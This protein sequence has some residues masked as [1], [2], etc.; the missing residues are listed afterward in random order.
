[1]G[2]KKKLKKAIMHIKNLHTCILKAVEIG[3]WKVDGRC[4][5]TLYMEL[6]EEFI[7]NNDY[8]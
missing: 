7:R 6:A 5:P 2:K 1:M 8:E 3:D 4:D